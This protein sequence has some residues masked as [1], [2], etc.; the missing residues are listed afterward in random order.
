MSCFALFQQYV[1]FSSGAHFTRNGHP[2][3]TELMGGGQKNEWQNA[4]DEW[5]KNRNERHLA[6]PELGLITDH[7]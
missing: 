1:A 2:L 3:K 5:L 6:F 4:T 7:G